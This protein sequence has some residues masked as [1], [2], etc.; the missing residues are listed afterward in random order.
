MLKEIFEATT[1]A[2]RLAQDVDRNKKEIEDMRRELHDVT[3][4]VRRLELE[5]RQ[6]SER[7]ERERQLIML[8]LENMLLRR[9]NLLMP[10][11]GAADEL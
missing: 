6:V 1:T 8:Q 9:R 3:S 2:L 10:P 4:T 7:E 5:L 11:E